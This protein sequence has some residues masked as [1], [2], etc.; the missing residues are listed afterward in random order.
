[1]RR[2]PEKERRTCSKDTFPKCLPVTSPPALPPGA[3]QDNCS[4]VS[5]LS[6]S[7]WQVRLSVLTWFK[8][9]K[10]ERHLSKYSCHHL[11]FNVKT[12][13]NGRPGDSAFAHFVPPR[14]GA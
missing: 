7:P 6:L 3:A 2:N 4:W 12:Q 5:L 14:A 11:I 1:M 13:R 10:I 8:K 9:K